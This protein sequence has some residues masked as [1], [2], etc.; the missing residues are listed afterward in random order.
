RAF[1]VGPRGA[2]PLGLA[3]AGLRWY[4]DEKMLEGTP[5]FT[6]MRRKWARNGPQELLDDSMRDSRPEPGFGESA[7]NL[8]WGFS[9]GARSAVGR[10]ALMSICSGVTFVILYHVGSYIYAMR[11]WPVPGEIK[12][13]KARLLFSLARYYEYIKP[14]PEKALGLLEQVLDLA[15]A[16]D[17]GIDQCSLAVLDAKLRIAQSMYSVGRK[18]D[19]EK[20]L[21]AVLPALRTLAQSPQPSYADDRDSHSGDWLSADMLLYRLC[22]LL[23]RVYVDSGRAAEA[24]ATYSRGLQAVKRMKEDVAATFDSDH[25]LDYTT[26]DNMNLKEALLT[27][28]LGQA[29]Y[30]AKNYRTAD[31]MFRATINSVKRHKAHMESAPRVIVNVWENKDQWVCMDAKAMLFLAKIQLDTGNSA[32]ALPW[33]VAGRKLTTTKWTFEDERCIRC[34]SDLVVQLGRIAEL[35]GRYPRA[36]QRYREAFNH[37]HLALLPDNDNLAANVA[38]LE[39]KAAAA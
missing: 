5:R 38:R 37:T 30:L 35:Q 22:E 39:A 23:G 24:V 15:A 10:A 14:N 6:R 28:G 21:D 31:T 18:A 36:L 1:L 4:S 2:A 7:P 32:A 12:G 29:F 11:A 26:Y 16:Q 34:E 17:G 9:E 13:V 20:T 8:K 25:A 3:R 27:C 19:A 33:I